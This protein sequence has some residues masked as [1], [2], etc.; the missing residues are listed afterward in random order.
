MPGNPERRRSDLRRG[1]ARESGEEE[2]PPH[3]QEV[4]SLQ[5]ARSMATPRACVG[6]V[7]AAR[8]AEES[9]ERARGDS[10]AQP[11]KRRIWRETPAV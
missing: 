1:Y 6:E 4:S 9:D 10:R 8:W 7:G 3:D 2:A 11:T 5:A